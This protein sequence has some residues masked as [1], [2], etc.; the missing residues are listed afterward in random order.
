MIYSFKISNLSEIGSAG[1][2]K[3]YSFVILD[4]LKN[5]IEVFE[6]DTWNWRNL[7]DDCYPYGKKVYIFLLCLVGSFAFKKH[8]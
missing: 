4:I 3:F 7:A 8:C 6:E 2:Q 5:V 1:F